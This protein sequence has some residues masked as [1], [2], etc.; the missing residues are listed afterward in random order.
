MEPKRPPHLFVYLTQEEFKL[1][2]AVSFVAF[3]DFFAGAYPLAEYSSPEHDGDTW[4]EL[5]RRSIRY[6][7]MVH[8]VG[9]NGVHVNREGVL[10]EHTVVEPRNSMYVTAL[11]SGRLPADPRYAIQSALSTAQRN[12]PSLDLDPLRGCLEK[13]EEQVRTQRAASDPEAMKKRYD[14]DK[15][16]LAS[17]G[18]RP[19][20]EVLN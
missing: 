7:A 8:G 15:E 1:A 19:I 9:F 14:H 6:L 18:V 5:F 11:L 20:R 3:S 2:Y 12:I 16:A 4:E 17:I 10:V 13:I